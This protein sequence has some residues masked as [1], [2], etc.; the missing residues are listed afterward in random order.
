M[1]TQ[2]TNNNNLQFSILFI[3]STKDSNQQF[4]FE[5]SIHTVWVLKVI[6]LLL[7]FMRFVNGFSQERS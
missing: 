2:K 6:V 5:K 1:K 4:L 3:I 7:A